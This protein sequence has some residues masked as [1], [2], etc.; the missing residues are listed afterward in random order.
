MCR[1]TI[2]RETWN[3]KFNRFLVTAFTN[4]TKKSILYVLVQLKSVCCHGHHFNHTKKIRKKCIS[5]LAATRKRQVAPERLQQTRLT[6]TKS[7]MVSM[8]VTK[9]GRMVRIIDPIFIDGRV[10]IND[11]RCLWLQS[12]R[13]SCDTSGRECLYAM[14]L[15]PWPCDLSVKILRRSFHPGEPLR[16]GVKPNIAILDLCKA[17]SRKRCKIGGN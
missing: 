1:C 9:L 13:L 3:L 8:G 5:A 14:H 7:V 11:T 4:P 2:P 15:V 6:F 16:R 12:Y 10:K 17:I